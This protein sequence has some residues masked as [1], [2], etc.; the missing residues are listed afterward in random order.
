MPCTRQAKIP[1][2]PGKSGRSQPPAVAL[3][4]LSPTASCDALADLPAATIS[5]GTTTE[6]AKTVEYCTAVREMGAEPPSPAARLLTRAAAHAFAGR[7][8]AAVRVWA[9]FCRD[10]V[11]L[12]ALHAGTCSSRPVGGVSRS[13]GATRVRSAGVS[14]AC[15]FRSSCTHI[16]GL[17]EA[18]G[19]ILGGSDTSDRCTVE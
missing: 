4:T 10:R 17:R 15:V 16:S 3:V 18:P 12:L 9:S 1:A 13:A 14:G 19:M 11:R 6:D 2:C 8:R 5:I 7:L